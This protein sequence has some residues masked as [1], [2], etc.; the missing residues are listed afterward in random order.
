MKLNEI[1]KV[2]T[3]VSAR[4]DA[5]LGSRA[6][7]ANIS[8]ALNGVG[9]GAYFSRQLE[10]VLAEVLMTPKAPLSGFMLFP[11]DTSLP[12]G[13]ET[14]VQRIEDSYGEARI[15]GSYAD[16]P[17][18]SDVSKLEYSMAISPIFTGFSYSVQDIAAGIMAGSSLATDRAAAAMEADRQKHNDVMFGGNV[19]TGQLGLHTHPTIPRVVEAARPT[20]A[21]GWAALL[22][23]G[24][25]RIRVRTK[26]LATGL[27]V[28]VS[29]SI[30][31]TVSKLNMGNGTD[32][33]VL[34]YV[35]RNNPHVTDII[36]VY[37]QGGAGAG[38][39]DLVSFV[40]INPMYLQYRA[41]LWRPMPVQVRNYVYSTPCLSRTGGMHIKMPVFFEHV[42]VPAA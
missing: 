9:G 36:E 33:T 25:S 23:D 4:L 15:G 8:T 29:T 39:A 20:T 22:N 21:A 7:G 38:G 31:E 12:E 40:P 42:E 17:P 24:V 30:F 35:K 14:Y 16:D 6:D 11:V 41:R 27:T 26:T 34:E 13:A 1:I 5:E 2:P 28:L 37:E 19:S 10:F 18:T 32:L 3:D